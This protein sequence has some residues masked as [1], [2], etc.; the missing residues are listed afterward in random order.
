MKLTKCT[1]SIEAKILNVILNKQWFN[2]RNNVYT[3]V[4]GMKWKFKLRGYRT[5]VFDSYLIMIQGCRTHQPYTSDS[6]TNTEGRGEAS[7]GEYQEEDGYPSTQEN[8]RQ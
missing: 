3:R 1:E 4:L 2:H 7:V 8:P 5:L 6:C